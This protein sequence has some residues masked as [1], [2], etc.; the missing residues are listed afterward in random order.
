V[1]ILCGQTEL[2]EL[3]AALHAVGRLADLLN[4]G[5]KQADQ[6]RNDRDYDQQLDQRETTPFTN[7][8]HF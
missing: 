7:K 2:L 3:V 4:R 6:D 1:V 5:Q 8:H